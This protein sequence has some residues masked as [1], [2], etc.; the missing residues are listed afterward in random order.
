MPVQKKSG[1]LLNA[2]RIRDL[3]RVVLTVI[4]HAAQIERNSVEEK[5]ANTFVVYLG[6][7]LIGPICLHAT[8]RLGHRA[9]YL[10]WRPAQI[11]DLKA[12]H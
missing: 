4:L 1:N 9:V 8:N 11:T 5:S 7:P 6:K 2:P 10:S 12:E 3:S